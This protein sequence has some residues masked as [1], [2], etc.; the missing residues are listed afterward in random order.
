MAILVEAISVVVQA[1]A[2][3]Y[4][5]QG[6][7]DAFKEI[8]PN[9]TLRADGEI[10]GVGFMTPVDVESFIKRLKKSGLIFLQDDMSLDIT[11]V[12]QMRGPTMK[13]E[14]LEFGH[15]DW[16]GKGHRIAACR[17]VDTDVR[18]IVTPPDW[19]YEKSLS[20]SF[21]FQPTE[22]EQEGLKFLRHEDG[23]DIYINALTGKEVYVGRTGET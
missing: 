20:A 11:V 3:L 9:K 21:G 7:W 4:K 19:V 23:V 5:F 22:H 1:E 2:I 13:C 14:W 18:Q 15:A 8:V 16:D 12:D 6:G 10:A 17:I